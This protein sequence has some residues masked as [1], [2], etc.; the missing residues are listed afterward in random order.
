MRIVLSNG[1]VLRLIFN[2]DPHPLT[3]KERRRHRATRAVIVEPHDDHTHILGRGETRAYPPDMFTRERGRQVALTKA[4]IDGLRQRVLSISEAI[5][6]FE[7]YEQR[8]RPI[9][10]APKPQLRFP[11]E[12]ATFRLLEQARREALTASRAV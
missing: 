6:I 3:K 12:T 2:R 10:T 5:Q 8:P 9:T 11:K 1:R 7:A 4:V